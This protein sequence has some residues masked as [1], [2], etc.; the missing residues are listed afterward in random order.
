MTGLTFSK[1][2]FHEDV[3][4]FRCLWLMYVLLVLCWSKLALDISLTT[5]LF[6]VA[7]LITTF[8][9]PRFP[10]SVSWIHF[11]EI[12]LASFCFPYRVSSPCKWLSLFGDKFLARKMI[13]TSRNLSLKIEGLRLYKLEILNHFY[14]YHIRN[15]STRIETGQRGRSPD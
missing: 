3:G 6:I 9:P 12:L 10:P 14:D 7:M 2:A 15:A 8:S 13:S 1:F 5:F 4:C 11:I